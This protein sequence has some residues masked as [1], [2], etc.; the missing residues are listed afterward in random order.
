[1]RH[2][3]V[4]HGVLE[5]L[6]VGV[7]VEL[8]GVLLHPGPP[9][10]LD[11]VV[12]PSRQVLR[13]LRP[14]GVD[15]RGEKIT[16]SRTQ[17]ERM[18][19]I[20]LEQLGF[21]ERERTRAPSKLKVEACS[22][23]EHCWSESERCTIRLLCAPCCLVMCHI[24]HTVMLYKYVRLHVYTVRR[25]GPGIVVLYIYLCTYVQIP[26]GLGAV[27]GASCTWALASITTGLES[28]LPFS[29]GLP[30]GRPHDFQSKNSGTCKLRRRVGDRSRTWEEKV[31]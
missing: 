26:Y 7:A 29:T 15:R 27:T 8:L 21:V 3:E 2:P 19:G 6:A 24:D 5:A 17:L 23:R 28:K 11:L 14:S 9:V 20:E 10:V 16:G 30:C 13:Y 18:R 1:V 22:F 25:Y 12:R 4:A 31:D